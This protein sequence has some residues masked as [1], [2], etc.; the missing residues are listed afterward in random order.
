MGKRAREEV[1]VAD[2]GGVFLIFTALSVFFVLF[3]SHTGIVLYLYSVKKL[4][5]LIGQ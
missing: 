1:N 2:G 5:D 3:I 4:S